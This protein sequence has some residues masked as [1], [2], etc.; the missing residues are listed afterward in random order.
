MTTIH[1]SYQALLKGVFFRLEYISGKG[2]SDAREYFRI[3]ACNADSELIDS[4]LR[5]TLASL[6]AKSESFF[7]SFTIVDDR[8]EVCLTDTGNKSG[9]TATEALLECAIIYGVIFRWLEFCGHP[10][11]GVW[12]EHADYTLGSLLSAMRFRGKLFRRPN[13]PM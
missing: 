4:L 13:P 12:S 10:D 9:C 11:S 6:C 7:H 1:F 3:A 8:V 5:E 2:A